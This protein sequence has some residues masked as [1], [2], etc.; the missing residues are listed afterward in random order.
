MIALFTIR[1]SPL[2]SN[3]RMPWRN[4]NLSRISL[5]KSLD[6]HLD[7]IYFTGLGNYNETW[8]WSSSTSG[9]NKL[10][11]QSVIKLFIFCPFYG[12]MTFYISII[13]TLRL[14]HILLNSFNI[15]LNIIQGSSPTTVNQSNTDNSLTFLQTF[16]NF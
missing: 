13:G 11:T 4:L 14:Q 5:L 9:L 10:L 6:R 2:M 12:F 16:N 15:T 1:F 7:F 3:C 8:K